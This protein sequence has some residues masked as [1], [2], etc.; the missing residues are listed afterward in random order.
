MSHHIVQIRDREIPHIHK[1]HDLTVIVLGG[2]GYIMW[3]QR[4][5]DLK[6]GDVLFI[7]RGLAHYY[8][9][10]SEE[11]AVAFA[12]YSPPFDGKDTIPVGQR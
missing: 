7:P 8:V 6:A 2:R 1:F 3:E 4:R 10:G 12:I 9:N 11:P 5:I